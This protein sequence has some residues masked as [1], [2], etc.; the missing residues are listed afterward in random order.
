MGLDEKDLCLMN[1]SMVHYSF[2]TPGEGSAQQ[3]LLAPA[4]SPLLPAGYFIWALPSSL[5]HY[6]Y[7]SAV[8][9]LEAPAASPTKPEVLFSWHEQ[10]AN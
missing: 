10:T 8:L 3:R 5:A 1:L 2:L 4:W 7:M 6:P 9:P